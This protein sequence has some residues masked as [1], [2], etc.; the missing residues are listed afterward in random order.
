[1]FSSY[2][3]L[4][5]NI[6]PEMSTKNKVAS[7]RYLIQLKTAIMEAPCSIII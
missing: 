2:I 4:S 3:P 5:I 6:Q 7:V 1:M